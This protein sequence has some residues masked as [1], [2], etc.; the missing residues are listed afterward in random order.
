ML[1]SD[2]PIKFWLLQM[3]QW[4][5]ELYEYDEVGDGDTE[6]AGQ[7]APVNGE[8]P[9]GPH[10]AKSVNIPD[11]VVQHPAVAVSLTQDLSLTLQ[12]SDQVLDCQ[13]G[14]LCDGGHCSDPHKSWINFT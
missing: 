1:V 10:G 3:S 2:W 4:H 8:Q 7:D 9:Q 5:P 14:I 6:H 13:E 12:G 11:D